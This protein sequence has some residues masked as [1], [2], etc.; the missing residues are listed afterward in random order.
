MPEGTAVALRRGANL[1]LQLHFH[2]TGEPVR[3]QSRVGFYFAESAPAKRLADIPLGSRE[4]DIPPGES[5]YKVR[6]AFT[7]PVDVDAIGI[8]PHAHYLCK[9]M[10]G[11]AV[12]PD[13]R[14]QW[15]LWIRDWDFNR[16]EQYRYAAP[17]RLPEGTRVE[18]EFTYDNS[19]GNPRN[20]NHP[21][22]RVL[23]G[24]DSGDEMAGLHI[25]VIP[26][27][28]ADAGELAAALWGKFMRTV[29]GGFYRR[30]EAPK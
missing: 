6:D 26:A 9:D 2:P 30:P 25:Q 19:D 13:G 24:P 16:Q 11:F 14:K 15:L 29:G 8:V 5:A 28:A 18:M 4:I 17:V 12:L 27:R 21:P 23:W 22:R 20:P 1:V 7:L 10:K 3:E